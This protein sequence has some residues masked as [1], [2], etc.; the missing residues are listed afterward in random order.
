MLETCNNWDNF[1]IGKYQCGLQKKNSTLVNLIRA[2]S[3]LMRYK[4]TRNKPILFTLDISKEFDSI[5]TS[6]ILKAIQDKIKSTE[7]CNK[8]KQYWAFST[9]LLKKITLIYDDTIEITATKGTP[10]GGWLSPIFFN[11]ALKSILN[12]DGSV[13]KDLIIEKKIKP[14]QM[15]Y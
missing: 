6:V 13:T 4:R 10:Q 2:K 14:L 7:T 12:E 9:Q 11:I 3:F 8:W 1:G 5:L 15:I